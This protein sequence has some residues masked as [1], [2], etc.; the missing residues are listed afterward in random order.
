LLERDE[1]QRSSEQDD[2]LEK[3]GEFLLS[4]FIF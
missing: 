1:N 4:F 3:V 2:I